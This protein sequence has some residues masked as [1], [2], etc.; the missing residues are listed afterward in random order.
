M[1]FVCIGTS[2][3]NPDGED[4]T[5]VPFEDEDQTFIPFDDAENEQA[6][7]ASRTMI[8]SYLKSEMTEDKL[9]ETMAKLNNMENVVV[10]HLPFVGG[11]ILTFENKDHRMDRMDDLSG[12]G[13]QWVEDRAVESPVVEEGEA[14]DLTDLLQFS[15]QDS[16]TTPDDSQFGKL[17]AYQ[18]LANNADINMQEGWYKYLQ[19]GGSKN[20]P[21]VVVAIVDT[22]IDYTHPDLKDMMWTNPGEIAGNGI[23]D[24]E[25][26]IVDDIYGANFA[27]GTYGKENPMDYGGHGTHVAGTVAATG[28][29]GQGVI[30]VASY[31]GSKVHDWLYL[32]VSMKY[33][34]IGLT[35]GKI[36]GSQGFGNSW[37]KMVLGHERC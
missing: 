31:A 1:G 18:N 16:T 8:G 27:Y 23:D 25:N 29:N 12:M 17:W 10:E 6:D 11:F 34:N 28:N 22:G 26:G 5:F 24:D 3:S 21:E 9:Q 15:R 36:D 14:L 32:K 35:L 33:N 19:E 30:G 20:G 4:H 2:W 37:R 7:V 13:V